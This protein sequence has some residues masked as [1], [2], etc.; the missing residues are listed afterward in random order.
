M[1]LSTALVAFAMLGLLSGCAA[2]ES[3]LHKDGA[4]GCVDCES[5]CWP[6][7]RLCWTR[8]CLCEPWVEECRSTKLPIC[9]P[10]HVKA[11]RE[12]EAREAAEAAAAEAAA[13]QATYVEPAAP[14]S[15]PETSRDVPET[16]PGS[17]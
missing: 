12:R 14:E 2:V 1:R 15:V 4:H 13:A 7:G 6:P 16:S 8:K 11:E 3:R 9:Q 10:C 5:R 17:P